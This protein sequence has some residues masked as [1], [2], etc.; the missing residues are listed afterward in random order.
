L[1][2]AADGAAA[3]PPPALLAGRRGVV[4][5]VSRRNALGWHVAARA[6]ALGAE[7]AVTHRPARAAAAA[8]AA[9]AAGAV[10]ALPLDAG[11]ETSVAAAFARLDEA[12]GR[13]DFLVHAIVHVPADLLARPLSQV[14]RAEW[15]LVLGTSAHSLVAACRHA[16]PLLAR[17]D[18]ARVVA[19]T[20]SGGRRALPRYHVAGIAKAALESAVRYLALEL[21]PAGVLCNAVSASLVPTEGALGAVGDAAAAAT[22]A[23]LARRAPTRRATGAQDVADAVAWLCSPFARNISGGILTIDGGFET[24]YL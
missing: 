13:L 16:A 19:L 1:S 21:G 18:A 15:D 17:S 7:V 23:H 14:T 4:L 22:L 2:G 12:W 24:L 10:L 11:D 9:A 6:R 8:E 20:S 3:A 5:G